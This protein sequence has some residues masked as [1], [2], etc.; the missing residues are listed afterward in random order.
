MAST[1]LRYRV[2]ACT[3][4]APSSGLVPRANS[5]SRNSEYPCSTSVS[6][7]WNCTISEP[8]PDR[9]DWMDC[10]SS[11]SIFTLENSGIR[12]RRAQTRNPACS[13]STFSATVFMATDFP[14]MLAPVITVAPGVS[15]MDTGTNRLPCSSSRSQISGLIMS[16]S[17]R[18]F[19]VSSGRTPP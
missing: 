12:A 16:S 5:S 15:V 2:T 13:S 1:P 6:A 9:P 19:S 4:T 3:I 7:F 8:K 10:R 11:N 18:S 14:P 17:S